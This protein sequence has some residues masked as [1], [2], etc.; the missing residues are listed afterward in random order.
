MVRNSLGIVACLLLTACTN[1]EKKVYSGPVVG[2]EYHNQNTAP[3]PWV[4]VV[5]SARA[6]AF[7]EVDFEL[8]SQQIHFD[9]A[10]EPHQNAFKDV[11]SVVLDYT[12]L[13]HNAPQTPERRPRY[14]MVASFYKRGNHPPSPPDLEV[15]TTLL[16]SKAPPQE[17]MLFMARDIMEEIHAMDEDCLLTRGRKITINLD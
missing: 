4:A 8:I 6:L 9:L 3:W 2:L 10:F 15:T 1:A 7:K 16:A 13:P 11:R 14:F 5:P 17:A 12:I